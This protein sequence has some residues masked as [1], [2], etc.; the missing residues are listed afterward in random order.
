MAY[1][2]VHIVYLFTVLLQGDICGVRMLFLWLWQF[3]DMPVVCQSDVSN[4]SCI[5]ERHSCRAIREDEQAREHGNLTEQIDGATF[6]EIA[7]SSTA[8]ITVSVP[9]NVTV[10]DSCSRIGGGSLRSKRGGTRADQDASKGRHGLTC[11]V[12]VHSNDIEGL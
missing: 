2:D 7:F 3:R 1:G 8:G 10:N 12:N 9:C 4:S 6:G 5:V 11:N